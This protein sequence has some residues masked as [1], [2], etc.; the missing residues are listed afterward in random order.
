[1]RRPWHKWRQQASFCREIKATRGC[2]RLHV[3][4]SSR[5]ALWCRPAK[6]IQARGCAWQSVL[7]QPSP[8]HTVPQHIPCLC[9]PAAGLTFP[10]LAKPLWADG[11]EGS[12]A[13]AGA[14]CLT[15]MLLPASAS[16]VAAAAQSLWSC[17]TLT[18]L[19]RHPACSGAHAAGPAA[20]GGWGG[21]LPSGKAAALMPLTPAMGCGT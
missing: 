20:A 5:G 8:R 2:T 12:H 7:H 13:L 11:R 19:L 17:L 18:A 14:D 10:M 15:W 21:A 1:M 9:H 4:S 3:A 6:R 16:A